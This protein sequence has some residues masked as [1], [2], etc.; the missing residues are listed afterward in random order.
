MTPKC[1]WLFKAIIF[2]S[3]IA[4]QTSSVSPQDTDIKPFQKGMAF[5]TWKAKQYCSSDSDKSLAILAEKTCTEWVQ[6]VP[7]WYQKNRRSNKITPDYTGQTARKKCLRHAI[8]TAH[9]LGLKVMLKPHVD[10][11][12]GDWR[13]NFRPTD[14]KAWF[15]NYKKMIK[16]YAKLASEENVEIF[17]VGCEFLKLTEPKFTSE[18]KK[19]I[20]IVRKHFTGPLVYSA[21]WSNEYDRVEFWGDLDYIGIDAYFKLTDKTDPTLDELLTSWKPYLVEIEAFYQTWK[22]PIIYTEIGYRSIDG[23]NIK[24]WDWETPGP[25]DLKEQVLCY[26]A[27]IKTF[28]GKS[29]FEGIYWWN[30]KPDPSIGGPDDTRYTPHMKP[31]EDILKKWYEKQ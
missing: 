6:L 9:N 31:A 12:N 29:W 1:H 23:A 17:S 5:P 27:V 26:K 4:F 18:W 30:W 21:N 25:I 19:I 10:A 16:N 22:I 8:Q 28:K 7:T 13:G 3:L 11:L 24:P 20:R 14:S 2:A 15:R